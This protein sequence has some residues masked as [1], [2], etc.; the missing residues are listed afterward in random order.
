MRWTA[1]LVLVACGKGGEPSHASLAPAPAVASKD[2]AKEPDDEEGECP[3]R[4][5]PPTTAVRRSGLHVRILPHER[6]YVT[7][8]PAFFHVI[9]DAGQEVDSVP[10]RTVPEHVIAMSAGYW[11]VSACEAGGCGPHGTGAIINRVDRT[12]GA[13]VQIAGPDEEIMFAEVVGDALYWA[14]FGEYGLTGALRR[15]PIA[16]GKPTTLWTGTAVNAVLIRGASAYVAD[17]RTVSAV[18]LSGGRPRTLVKDLRSAHGLAVDDTYLYVTDRGDAYHAS[19]DSGSVL[20]VPLAG[21]KPEQLAGPVRWPTVVGVDD[22]RV[23]FMGD[24]SGDVWAIPKA[25]GTPALY[26]PMPPQDWPCRDSKWL[27][28]GSQGLAYLR[29]SRGVDIDSGTLWSIRREWMTDPQQQFKHVVAKHGAPA[30]DLR[31]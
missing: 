17:D 12:T 4:G 24:D 21:G 25:G 13:S 1:W 26:I 15:V 31:P 8:A 2:S 23:Y 9:D 19:N 18:P 27:H 10:P 3:K 11:F 16:G 28:V 30:D 7:F 5:G 22:D 14:T 29:M 6:G 20:R